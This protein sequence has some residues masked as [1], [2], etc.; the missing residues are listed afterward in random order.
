MT[1]RRYEDKSNGLS[2]PLETSIDNL[3]LELEKL[4]AA[5]QEE[6]PDEDDEGM[7]GADAGKSG[8]DESNDESDASA[9]TGRGG[10]VAATTR[11]KKS[12]TPHLDRFG[13][14][15]TAMARAGKLDPVEG[16]GNEIERLVQIL[17][18]RKKNN[19]VLVGEAGVGKSAVVEGLAERIVQRQ[20][21]RSLLDK[22]IVSLD[23]GALVAGTKY[24]GQF[25][26]RLKALID[27]LKL[28]K[29]IILF[30][31]ELHTIVGAGAAQGSLDTANILKPPLAR[32]E[33]QC[34]GA[35]TLDEYRKSI[36][37]DAA[38]ERRFQKIIVEPNTPE[39]TL[40]ILHCLKPRYEEFHAVT[41]TDAALEAAVDLSA[42]YI[43]DRQ[44]PDKAIDA[45]D[46][47]AAS[48]RTAI[49]ELPEELK[50]L[51]KQLVNLE[52]SRME[53]VKALNYE[54]AAL[55]RDEERKVKLHL[56]E[57]QDAWLKE[58]Q[59]NKM[60][61]DMPDVARVVSLSTGIPL[62]SLSQTESQ[63][64][65]YL[66]HDL[67][68]KVLGQ[69]QAVDALARS[70]QRNRL[71][72]RNEKRPIG[73]FLFVGPTGVGKTYLA[74]KL[75]EALFNDEQA[76]IRFD[77][78]EYMEKHTVSRMMGAPPGYVGYEEGGQLSEKVRRKP[79]SVLLF[80]EIEKAHPDVYNV[81][82]Q[83]MDEGQLTDGLGRRVDFKNTVIII[84]SN[85][86]TRQLK[87]FGQGV[88]FKAD[89][90]D[91]ASNKHKRSVIQKA[92]NRTFNP[93]FLNRLDEIIQFDP[94]DRD[95]IRRIVDLELAEVASRVER[96][97]YRIE[98]SDELKEYLAKESY[99]PQYGARPLKRTL[100]REV[101]DK[102]TDM[103]LNAEIEKG[104]C[105]YLTLEE[106]KI[107]ATAKE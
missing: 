51:E 42:R 8:S 81:L 65:R 68:A 103:V 49:V 64:L 98:L 30:I 59:E 21:N 105:L 16:R 24:R 67:K 102:L 41:Y 72:L 40:R 88:G 106:E 79:Y 86:G 92:L 83:V 99:D 62:E 71:G 27:E 4:E 93:E 78:S 48:K 50:Q 38:L 70:I 80:D 19:P 58:E 43:S 37:K 23:M 104:Q 91:A 66:S 3:N 39:E 10:R 100:Q 57:V 7:E 6:D 47:A 56:Q 54:Q 107:V 22:R 45:M 34:I 96:A 14:D 75:A 90:T 97:G 13:T 29:Q 25:E 35:T 46:E 2:R 95:S 33:L 73:V 9:A 101:E 28:N 82:L 89:I 69:D 94:L 55:I 44:F 26:E 31:D 52:E 60:L 74:K 12:K 77:M 61:V 76:M 36:E 11:S 85:A 15:L 63:R 1:N 17:S 32:G 87:D 20:V 84:T 53:A 18:R 5:Y